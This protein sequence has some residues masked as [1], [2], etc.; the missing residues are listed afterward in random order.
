LLSTII[1]SEA[2]MKILI[3]AA[4]PQEYSPLKKLLRGRRLPGKKP[5]KKFAFN[6]PG[7]EIVLI[8]SGM[9][10]ESAEEALRL[11]TAAF[12]PDLLIFSGFAGGLHPELK[13]GAVCYAAAARKT[14]SEDL[15]NFRFSREL[16]DFLSQNHI[17]PVLA[18]SSD[19]PGDKR[20][21]SALAAGQM[22]V[23][24]METAKL[25][26]TAL[27][28]R[29]PFICFRAVSDCL[30]H[31]LGFNLSDISDERGRVRLSGVLCTILR[32]P[33]T[34]KA[35]FLSWR[36][37]SAAARN[38]CRSVAAFLRIP[39]PTLAGMAAGIRIER[40]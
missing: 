36:R 14:T 16:E 11:E 24:D 20:A 6:L 26:E 10:A 5:L 23:S 13:I 33:A 30:D 35:F 37:S 22:A 17:I 40:N 39:A 19:M 15:F 21:L 4:L 7:R 38:L 28:K 31:E 2:R 8:E 27:Q 9:G 1:R 25:A 34:L 18:I 3:L 32:R 12:S 29:A